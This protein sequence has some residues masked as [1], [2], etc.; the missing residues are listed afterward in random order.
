MRVPQGSGKVSIEHK[1]FGTQVDL[2]PRVL[3]DGRIRM[4]VRARHS[5]LDRTGNTQ[6]Y[7]Y[8]V[9]SLQTREV[10]TGVEIQAGKTLV[11]GGLDLM[12]P[13]AIKKETD[14]EAKCETPK[15]KAADD[16]PEKATEQTELLVLIT[17]QIIEPAV[18]TSAP[19]PSR[20][21]TTR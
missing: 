6:R 10:E 1:K 7:G 5:K 2:V 19:V 15:S 4:E 18:A 14:P 8:T 12:P 11:I 3:Q 9:P 13:R 17:P 21:K 16:K 20:Q